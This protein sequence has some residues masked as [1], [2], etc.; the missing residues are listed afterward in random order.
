MQNDDLTW[1]VVKKVCAFR[2]QRK[3]QTR[4]CRHPMNVDALCRRQ[5]CPLANSQYATVIDRKKGLCL[6]IRYPEKVYTPRYQWKRVP[7]SKNIIE[8]GQTIEDELCFWPEFFKRKCRRRLLRFDEIANNKRTMKL[9]VRQ[10][11]VAIHPKQERNFKKR[12]RKALTAAKLEKT[13]IKNLL[14]RLKAGT[15]GTKYNFEE[16]ERLK[17]LNEDINREEREDRMFESSDEEEEE[18]EEENASEVIEL[19]KDLHSAVRKEMEKVS[20]NKRGE[21]EG[22][23]DSDLSGDEAPR[24][25]DD[26]EQEDEDTAVRYVADSDDSEEEEEKEKE[27]DKEKEDKV[28][29]IEDLVGAKK[30]PKNPLGFVRLLKDLVPE[31]ERLGLTEAQ[32]SD[33]I[34]KRKYA[35]AKPVRKIDKLKRAKSLAKKNIY[36][37]YKKV[38]EKK[39]QA[40]QAVKEKVKRR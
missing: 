25:P 28:A 9:Y 36:Y 16:K 21:Y 39:Q 37:T 11:L 33:L 19:D 40:R 26:Y 2:Q 7:L 32:M 13:L 4:F 34:S 17:A 12:E 14:N 15:Y 27:E 22:T 38:Q 3:A 1:E 23:D 5:S 30:K 20:M 18:E 6:Y 29:D 24:L 8:A 10:K 35:P 31:S